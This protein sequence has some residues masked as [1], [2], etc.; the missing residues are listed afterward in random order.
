LSDWVFAQREAAQ[1]LCELSQY[2]VKTKQAGGDV[3]FI[4]TVRQYVTPPDPTMTFFASA[5]KQTNQ[6]VA[7][8][9]PSGWGKT[10]VEALDLCIRAI[11][12]FPYPG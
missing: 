4:I 1:Q 3:E 12:R 7:A 9:T 11:G 5:D 2:G 8:F 6:S 10:K